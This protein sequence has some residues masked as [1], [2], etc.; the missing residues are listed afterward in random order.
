MRTSVLVVSAEPVGA[1]MAGPA[2][3]AYELARALAGACDVTLA[4]PAPSEVADPRIAPAS[5][6]G[7]AEVEALVAAAREHDVVVAQELPPVALERLARS[8]TRLVADLYNPVVVE[9]LAGVA[10]PAAARAAPDPRPDRRAHGRALRGGRPRDLRERAPARPLDRR[11]G[12]ARARRRRGLPAAT[13]RCARSSRSCRSGCRTG[14]RR[15]ATGA[16]RAA[17]PAIGADDRVLVWGGGVWGW[18][19]PITPMRAVERMAQ[20]RRPAGAPRAARRRPPGA[21]GDRAGGGRRGGRRGRAARRAARPARALQRGLGALRGARRLAGRGGHRGLGASRPDRGPLRAS[22]ADPRLPLGGPAGGRLARRR[23]RRAGRARAARARS[24][25]PGTWPASRPP[26]SGCS[27]RAGDEARR[28]I[29]DVAPAC[30]GSSVAA[31][32]VAWCADAAARPRRAVRRAAMR[33]AA[34]AQYRWALRET[35][36]D[37][38]AG[39]AAKR[40]GAAAATGGAAAMRTVVAEPGAASAPRRRSG[41]D[42]IELAALAAL[43]GLSLLVLA[44]LLTKGR[45]LTGADGLLASDQLQYFTWIRQAGEHWLIGNE[46]DLAPGQPRLPPPGFLLSGLR[47]RRHRDQRAAQLPALEAGRRGAAV[48]GR[49]ALRAPPAAGRR[50]RATSRSCSG[51]SP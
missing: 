16:L 3:R 28:R 21:R 33:R 30:A 43:A 9:L 4:A 31:P 29:A 7:M 19:D 34:L 25:I 47:Q 41:L 15:R 45:A 18:L 11:D 20:A 36:A 22:R 27:G 51:S 46:Y 39:A 8:P 12:P 24:P 49:A 14:R 23:A 32:L 10:E 42:R 48:L 6:A 1:R 2:I 26:A 13:R 37:E 35:L 40:V 50:R 17:F 38:G 44:A 5:Q